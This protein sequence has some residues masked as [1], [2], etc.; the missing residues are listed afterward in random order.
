MTV[1]HCNGGISYGDPGWAQTVVL[2]EMATK[3][4]AAPISSEASP[5]SLRTIEACVDPAPV[6][7]HDRADNAVF[8]SARVVVV[9]KIPSGANRYGG[10]ELGHSMPRSKGRG[11]G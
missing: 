9:E 10:S 1:N 7:P 4:S 6:Q 5:L 2:P 11:E 8:R 3:I